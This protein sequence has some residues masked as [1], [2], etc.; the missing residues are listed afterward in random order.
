MNDFGLNV[1][2]P[3]SWC[4]SSAAL[5]TERKFGVDKM[6]HVDIGHLYVQE[7]VKT[8]QVIVGK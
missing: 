1:D 6:G 2:T 5:Q 8:K 3:R 7:L 4:D